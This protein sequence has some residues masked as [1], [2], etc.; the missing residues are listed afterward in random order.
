MAVYITICTYV[1]VYKHIH[2]STNLNIKILTVALFD[3]SIMKIF[4]IWLF[5]CILN[6]FYFGHAC[7]M[8]K[9]Q[10]LKIIVF[11]IKTSKVN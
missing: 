1:F 4:F 10:N 2:S 8:Q 9:E 7:A 6:I 11:T 5:M 3:G